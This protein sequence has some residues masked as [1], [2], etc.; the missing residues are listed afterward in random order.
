FLKRVE[1][2]TGLAIDII[3]SEE[4]ARLAFAGCASLLTEVSKRAVVFD[5]GG[6][7]TELMWIDTNS[8]AHIINDWLSIG[9]GVM[10]LADKFGG[11]NFADLAFGDMVSF[12]KERLEAF[13]QS[14]NITETI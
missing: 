9:F 2:E 13:D 12:V 3:S 6:G 14:N 8:G 5:I 7:S 4:E 11:P 10:N 1:A